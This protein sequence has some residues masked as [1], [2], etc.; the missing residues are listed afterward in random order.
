MKLALVLSLV[1]SWTVTAST[2]SVY[3]AL[4][5]D[6]RLSKFL[7]LVDQDEVIQLFLMKRKVTVFAPTN[8]AFDKF[9]QFTAEEENRLA[10][11]YV[12]NFVVTKDIFPDVIN[13]NNQQN[14]PLYLTTSDSDDKEE[15]E[16]FVNN[17]K[18]IEEREYNIKDGKQ[19]L[20]II[21]E[22]LEPY[23]SNTNLPPDAWEF[24]IQP[25]KYNLQENL[26]A[27]AS[28]VRS[29]DVTE[30]FTRVGNH[31]FFLPVGEGNDQNLNRLRDIDGKV[32]KG[33]IIPNMVLFT[34]TMGMEPYR[35]GAYDP[36]QLRVEL[37][38][39]N[40][41]NSQ[42][43]GYTLF[44]QSNTLQ[45]DHRHRKG[46]VLSKIL[47]SNIPVK[48]GVIHLI[49]AP[50]MIINITI[51]EFLQREADG[52]LYEFNQLV[53]HVSEFRYELNTAQ[54]K[55]VF[56]PTNEAIRRLDNL[57]DLKGNI[58]AITNLV[59]LHMV[60]RSVSTDD[61]RNGRIKEHLAADNRHSLYFRVVG[62]DRNR[63]LTVDG[64]GVNATAVQADIGAT[65]GIVHIINRVLGMPFQTVNE[66]LNTDPELKESYR[67]SLT[68]GWNNKLK[69]RKNNFTFFVP[70]E[71]AWERM[72]A[73]HPTEHKQVHME[74]YS[75]QVKKILDRHL[76]VGQELSSQD[77][78]RLGQVD[79]IYGVFKIESGYG[80]GE[81]YVE[82]ENLR[83]TIVRPDVQATN[84]IIHVIDRVM[85]KPRDLSRTGGSATVSMSGATLLVSLLLLRGM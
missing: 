69:D 2:K 49:E 5:G 81:L 80:Y 17:A 38:L 75:N 40:Q 10:T 21:D 4:E 42:G 53:K 12:V 44:A 58:T 70:S 55:T 6:P 68:D 83:A 45:S 48:N 79:T 20:L 13:S 84:G 36:T 54:E 72:K 3:E 7:R 22:V 51:L 11:F 18:I 1:L 29:E 14:A 27:F 73:E 59:R 8:E 65:N 16:Y 64:G 57:N 23:R 33:H 28:R 24:L 15:K 9:R 25:S 56:V 61:V 39:V 82:W 47:R 52:R 37:S 85:M 19:K 31:T 74:M 43:N 30:L 71:E 60:M 35:T 66:K 62:E 77:L 50:L 67:L 32:I 34:R 78:G 46:V 41:T 63:T 76:V 26:G